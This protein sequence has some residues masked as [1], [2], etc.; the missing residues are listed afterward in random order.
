VEWEAKAFR[1]PVTENNTEE[2][3]ASNRRVDV[4]LFTFQFLSP[5]YWWGFI[6]RKKLIIR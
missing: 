1:K 2:G 3:K 4:K 5:F 6:K